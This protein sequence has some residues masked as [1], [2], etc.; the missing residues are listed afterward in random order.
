MVTEEEKFMRNQILTALTEGM[1]DLRKS[2][3]RKQKDLLNFGGKRNK[4]IKFGIGME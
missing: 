1:P 2:N 3:R 4:D